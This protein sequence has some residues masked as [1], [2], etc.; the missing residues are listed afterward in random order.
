MRELVRD[1]PGDL[2][3]ISRRV[4]HAA[5]HEDGP[6]G[7]RKG[8]D[9]PAI[10]DV[11]RVSEPRLLQSAGDRCDQ[12]RADLLDIVLRPSIAGDRQ[13]LP[14]LRRRAPAQLD[15]LGCGESIRVWI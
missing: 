5:I 1:H 3:V 15:V 9:L 13:L 6:P 11:K 12:T 4:E 8:I 14:E 7:E 10:D 2:A